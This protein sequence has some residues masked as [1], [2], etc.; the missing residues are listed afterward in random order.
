M[1]KRGISMARVSNQKM[2]GNPCIDNSNDI[3]AR[4]H[5]LLIERVD[6]PG[7]RVFDIALSLAALAFL[8]PLLL[9]IIVMIRSDGGPAF[10]A[11][12]RVGRSGVPFR[13]LKLRT[14]VANAESELERLLAT[15][16][17][18]RAQW[19]ARF[20]LDDDPRISRIGRFLRATSL[21]ELPQFIN[22]LRG[23]MSLVG[24]RPIVEAELARYGEAQAWYLAQRPGLT[25]LWQVS[26]RSDVNYP[27]RVRLDLRYLRSISFLQDLRII[28]ATAGIVFSRQGAR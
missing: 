6:Y 26:G 17:A 28:L 16:P 1:D 19:E 20:K 11:H 7:K 21:D 8:A 13:C 24:P 2:Y 9:V 4:H 10:F 5:P 27:E 25:G 23:D 12:T 18:A 3:P 15:D 14:M 22:V